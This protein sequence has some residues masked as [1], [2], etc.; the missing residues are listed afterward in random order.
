MHHFF[1]PA[2]LSEEALAAPLT[3]SRKD[4]QHLFVL[5]LREGEEF[6]L[7]DGCGRE[8]ICR[9][10]DVQKNS[11]TASVIASRDSAR[12]LDC[13]LI[14]LQGL[15]K[16]DKLELI[17]QKAVELG[18]SSIVPVMMARSNVRLDDKKADRKAE[19]LN[20]IAKSAAEQSKRGIL[21]EVASPKRFA[22]AI[23]LAKDADIKL[24]CYEDE[25]AAGR[26]QA[27]LP[28]LATANK[29]VL[30]VGPEGGIS[31]E[32]WQAATCA[33]FQSV[34][35]GRRILRTETAGLCLLSF[36]MLHLENA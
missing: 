7:A 32:E 4:W 23:A 29:I 20:E 16:R 33:G 9:V 28:Q 27:L 1:L 10:T 17:I 13:Q 2:P 36:L 35:L 18:A 34:S 25:T 12:E 22:D 26:L 24:I 11:L 31:E 21:P 8:H 19:R 30:L 6:V 15:P 14:L 5:R 3:F